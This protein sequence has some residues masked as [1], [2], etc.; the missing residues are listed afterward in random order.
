MEFLLLE[1]VAWTQTKKAHT[2]H[3]LIKSIF[4]AVVVVAASVGCTKPDFVQHSMR[5][6]L[7]VHGGGFQC[8]ET[9]PDQ[10]IS[11]LKTFIHFYSLPS[12]CEKWPFN[13][14]PLQ[15]ALLCRLFSVSF[16]RTRKRRRRRG[17][18]NET[19]QDI[20]AL[21]FA[22]GCSSQRAAISAL[23]FIVTREEKHRTH[24][25]KH[26]NRVMIS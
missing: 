23:Q 12:K 1:L 3:H 10:S 13:A 16:G 15:N 14:W 5:L 17:V 25:H 26:T 2:M 6:H 19:Q 4:V 11:G 21:S 18:H 24:W 8:L 9:I 22:N 7:H 20:T